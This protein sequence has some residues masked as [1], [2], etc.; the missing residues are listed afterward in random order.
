MT[1]TSRP[2]H[3]PWRILRGPWERRRRCGGWLVPGEL[4]GLMGVIAGLGY[5]AVARV[6]ALRGTTIWDPELALDR[7][8]PF[9]DWS[10]WIYLT[11]YL[12]FLLPMIVTA[13]DDRG[14]LRLFY[15]YKALLL[16]TLISFAVFLV[17]PCEIRLLDQLPTGLHDRGLLG[18]AYQTLHGIDRPWN[19]WPSLHVSLS[20]MIVF[21]VTHLRR[22]RGVSNVLLWVHWLLLAASITTTKQHHLVDLVTGVLFGAFAWFRWVRP[23][24]CYV[25]EASQVGPPKA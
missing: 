4:L 8:I 3:L 17:L 25:D 13:R 15:L 7:A 22:G 16:V 14:L 2:P 18:F 6:N 5:I 9:F 12:Y 19:A 20:V 24:L 10:I 11:L 1:P 23:G 21:Y